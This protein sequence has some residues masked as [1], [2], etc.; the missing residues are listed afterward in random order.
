MQTDQCGHGGRDWV[1]QPQAKE[2]WQ[3]PEPE[4]SR[5][6]SSPRASA[7]LQTL[8][9]RTVTEHIPV[10]LK[11]P[12]CGDL[13]QLPQEMNTVRKPGC[14]PRWVW[15]GP[16]GPVRGN[17]LQLVSRERPPGSGPA[18]PLPR[19][20]QWRAKAAGREQ[21]SLGSQGSALHPILRAVLA[22]GR[23]RGRGGQES[24]GEA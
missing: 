23:G 20:L 8:A 21:P 19:L 6:G 2:R 14:K 24:M 7:R 18:L 17:K 9:P 4:E 22:C 12:I 3:P 16:P 10:V 13:M 5:H 11:H 1:M 15:C